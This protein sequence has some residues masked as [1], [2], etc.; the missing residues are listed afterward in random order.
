MPDYSTVIKQIYDLQEYAIKLG[1][2]NI[3]AL[4]NYL[5]NPHRN[6]PVIHIA[7]TNGKG[8]TAFF[9]AQ[10]L[11]ACGLK[12]G[13]FTSP[14][15]SD[16]RERVRID[17]ELIDEMS[18]IDF[19]EKVRFLVMKQK[20]TFFDTS[21]ALALD[22]FKNKMVDVAV[23]ETGLG[24][25][26][27]S[28]NIVHAEI[29][30]ITP[31]NFDHQK[32]LGNS[33]QSIAAEKAGIIK[34]GC[35]V[36]TAAQPI[37]AKE[38]IIA[39]LSSTN[40]QRDIDDYIQT[41]IN[42]ISLEGSVFDLIDMH[43]H[44]KYSGIKTRQIGDFQ[45]RNIALAYATVREFLDKRGIPFREES[46]KSALKEAVWP[47]RLQRVGRSPDIFFDVS[48][49]QSGIEKTLH[50]LR[51]FIPANKLHIITGL[52]QDK[53]HDQIAAVLAANCAQITV[54]EPDTHRRLDG[55]ILYDEIKKTQKNVRLIK[56]AV[57]AY[58][59]TKINMRQD[60]TLLVIGSHYLIGSLLKL[61]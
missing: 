35:T 58:E 37:D 26:L 34:A 53:N 42:S 56:D 18:I 20:A 33:L 45:I 8:S 25:K 19:W 13:L 40:T 41:N 7:G 55:K 49:N 31:I 29:C 1:L 5:E 22:Y 23:I 54:C 12:T 32:Q 27:D 59:S 30:V 52:V 61:I 50:F 47:G 21:T 15:L 28:T 11:S 2:D 24:G 14:H 43:Y 38:A 4:M 9:L 39:H 51:R 16:Y 46:L 44:T 48:H 10:I 36:I 60:E 6:Y 57:K 17:N 3:T